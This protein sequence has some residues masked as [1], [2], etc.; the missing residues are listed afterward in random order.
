MAPFAD[1]IPDSDALYAL[2]RRPHDAI[3]RKKRQGIDAGSAA[4]IG[5]S[6]FVL[7]GAAGADGGLDVSPRGGDPGFVRVHRTDDADYV[8][9]PD[10][11]GNNLLDTL[12]AIVATGHAGLLFLVP[13]HDE[14][15]RLNGAAWVVTDADVLDRFDELRRPKAAIAVRADEVFVHCAKAFRRS[16]LW[17]PE[18]WEALADA[19]GIETIVC[20]QG[21][22]GDVDPALIRADLEASY[23]RDLALDRPE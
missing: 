18:S 17:Q 23:V 6:P 9:I 2:Y 11:N 13:G 15:V 5:L 10:L 21:L 4:Y 12:Q 22:F 7:I 16:R 3:V 19:P 20:A 14:T 8:L 1:V